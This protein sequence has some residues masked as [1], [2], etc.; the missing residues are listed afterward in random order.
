MRDV[1]LAIQSDKSLHRIEMDAN[2]RNGALLADALM[3]TSPT[4]H[5]ENARISSFT[6]MALGEAAM[7]LAIVLPKAD[8]EAVVASYTTM[9]LSELERLVSGSA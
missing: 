1:W 2:D 9:A 8:A 4:L 5:P 7:R 6:I 3:R